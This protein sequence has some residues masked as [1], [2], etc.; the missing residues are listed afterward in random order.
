MVSYALPLPYTHIWWKSRKQNCSVFWTTSEM[1]GPH[2]PS[3]KQNKMV[4]PR[5]LSQNVRHRIND[6][7]FSHRI[8]FN[9]K[10]T[11]Q[12]IVTLHF[13]RTFCQRPTYSF[14]RVAV[15]SFI[16]VINCYAIKC[17]DTKHFPNTL[18]KLRKK[19]VPSSEFRRSLF[20]WLYDQNANITNRFNRHICGYRIYCWTTFAHV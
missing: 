6:P 17:P 18:S 8:R 9:G 19:E 12:T 16:A 1:D 14:S 2:G 13:C 11:V 10:Y 3:T 5:K 20:Y 7:C 4:I 15:Q